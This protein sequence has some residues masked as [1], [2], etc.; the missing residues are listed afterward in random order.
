MHPPPRAPF[1]STRS[2][3]MLMSDPGSRTPAE[4]RGGA[5]GFRSESAPDR[6]GHD[7][8]IEML[9]EHA[10]SGFGHGRALCGHRGSVFAIAA[11]L[12]SGVGDACSGPRAAHP[13]FA[14]FEVLET[15]VKSADFFPQR[16]REQ[17]GR[18]LDEVSVFPQRNWKLRDRASVRRADFK[19]AARLAIKKHGASVDEIG[20]AF[21]RSRPKRAEMIRRPDIVAVEDR[22]P[23]GLRRG[24]RRIPRGG[25]S[26]VYFVAE[27]TNGLRNARGERADEFLGAIPRTVFHQDQ[28]PIGKLLRADRVQRFSKVALCLISWDAD[29]DAGMTHVVGGK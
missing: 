16:L 22:D 14:I 27:K 13:H 18:W 29:A 26:A 4:P 3:K 21:T 8:P 12:A 2:L 9:V 11:S 25:E 19:I 7:F 24:H 28:F 10:C 6:G 15:R 1:Q 23:L 20:V 5:P 17:H